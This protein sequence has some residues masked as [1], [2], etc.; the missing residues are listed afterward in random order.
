MKRKIVLAVA[1]SATL[2]ACDQ[3]AAEPTIEAAPAAMTLDSEVKRVSYGMGIG[4]GQRIK[5]ESFSIDADA[6]SQGVKDAIDGA[7]QLM[8]QEEIMTEMQAFQQQQMAQQ[9]EEAGKIA[10][11]NMAEGE[12]FLV[13]NGTKDGGSQH[14]PSH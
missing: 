11:Q 3:Q 12:S 14:P 2:I 7:E 13:E 10:E 1:I 9:Q 4:L 8:S 5:Q 6:F